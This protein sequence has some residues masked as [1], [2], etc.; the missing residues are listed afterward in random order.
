MISLYLKNEVD[1][2]TEQIKKIVIIPSYMPNQKLTELV[3]TLDSM[4]FK[5]VVVNDGSTPDRDHIFEAVSSKAD[6]VCHDINRGKGAAIK[7]GLKYVKKHF[8]EPYVIVTADSDGQHL[9]EDIQRVCAN[10]IAHPDCFILGSRNIDRDAPPKSSFGNSIIRRIF[11]A[12]TLRSIRDTQTGLRAFSHSFTDRLIL[13]KGDR[14]E[15]EM[16]VLLNLVK[17]HIPIAEVPVHTVYFDNNSSTHFRVMRDSL[18]I[19]REVFKY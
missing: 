17:S 6:V 10:A 9:P 8:E 11:F 2:V 5:I 12:V 14:Y 13:I 16:K 3:D 15:Y 1:I 19:L 18:R 7:T 4:G